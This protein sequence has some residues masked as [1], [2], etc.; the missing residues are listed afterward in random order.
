VVG[1]IATEA[2]PF[3]V[4]D[5]SIEELQKYI[6]ALGRIQPSS[7]LRPAVADLHKKR[8]TAQLMACEKILDAKPTPE[9]AQAAVRVKLAALRLLGK[10][11]DPTAQGK[12]EAT[13]DQV[14]QL[15]LK[16][17]IRDV[18]WAALANLA[19]RAGT[20]D[21]QAYGKLVERLKQFLKSWPILPS[22]AK[23]C[24]NVASAAEQL[25]RSELAA[26]TY[27]ELGQVLTGSE[28]GDVAA[29]AAPMLGAARRLELVGKPFRL[30][31]STVA[32]KPLD[33]DNYR[34]KV[35]LVDF[36][37]TGNG[38]CREETHNIL[39]CYRAYRQR[40]FEVVGVSVD[41]DRKAIE[42][43][44]EKEPLP[45][46]ILLDLNEARGTDKSMATYYGIFTIPQMILVDRDGRVVALNVR[47]QQLNKELKRLLDAASAGPNNQ[48]ADLLSRPTAADH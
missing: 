48:Q 10:L 47:G 24:I 1:R 3:N 18:Q 39:A 20:M 33:W 7:S 36:F 43:F 5:G 15:G 37:A 45:W 13:V 2:D 38:P 46:T 40:G 41:H 19:Q 11:G 25:N 14:D 17:L 4:P 31:G 42:E 23:L 30:Q 29:I 44:V 6:D 16:D 26:T 34:G 21:D 8:A 28:D 32:G 35:V 22:A 9:Q 12:L 27:R